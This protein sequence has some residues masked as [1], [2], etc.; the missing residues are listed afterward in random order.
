MSETRK[1][2]AILVA[3]VVGYSRL[4][5]ADEDRTLARLR[6]LRSDLI[7]PTIAVHHG[8][9]VKRTGDGT[10]IE[11]R[12]V[13]D[14]VRCAIEVQNGMVE[15]NAGLP[16]ERRI[17][18]RIG[19]HLG[20]VVE[21]SDGDLMGDGVNIA[22]RLEGIAQPGSIC[23]S[24]AAYE[25]VRDKVKEQ[26]ADLGEQVLKNIERPVRVYSLA[27]SAINPS[28]APLAETREPSA[29]Q[30]SIA[31]LPFTCFSEGREFKFLT[32]AMTEDLI[33]MLARIPGFI[34][35]A[36]QSS[37]A[38]QGRSVDSRQIGRELGVHYIIEGSLRPVGQQL[39]VGTQLIDATT[40]VQLWADR[41]DGQAE[42]VLELQDQIARAIAS[43][44]EPELVRA[45]VAL[46]RRRRDANPNAWSCFRQGAGVISLKGWSE[47]TLTQATAL[48][49]QATTLDPDF[50]LARAQLALFL[51]LG[52]RL[53][54]V[55]DGAAAVTEARAEAERA[56]TIDHDAS[57]VLGYA[58]CALAELGDVQRGS[59]I[60]ERAIEND[61]SNAQAWVALGTSLCFLEKSGDVGLEKLR[62]G[63]RLSPRDHRLGFWGTFYALA[64]ARHRRLTE[65]HEEVRAACRRDPQ[66]YVARIVLA[67]TAAGL[68]SKEEAIAALRE[69][70]RLRPRL[71]LD[72][73]QLF[74]GRRG[75]ALLAPLWREVPKSS[76]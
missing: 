7:D 58:G 65:A 46:I 8:R 48:L 41:F 76:Q 13:V 70:Q 43:R 49:R 4:A 12:S 11:F 24:N 68:G 28:T 14:A 36:R 72:E 9:V 35:I 55:A 69:A 74:V 50:A 52:A 66:F 67:F 64:L 25:Q 62:H 6:A 53:G 16:T 23:L 10:L 5:G 47:E 38:Y 33:T 27:S 40:G 75:A 17:E 22:A 18:F 31:V 19:I 30:P 32:E 51:S 39:R 71:S 60:L 45:E 15:R 34:V 20:D 3:D 29:D 54:L 37:F 57:E 1:I 44:I 63:M 61:P 2:A 21:E 73:I 56:V 59:E 42:N 26:Y